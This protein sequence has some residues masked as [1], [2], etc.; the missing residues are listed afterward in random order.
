MRSIDI[1]RL[2]LNLL[3]VFDAIYREKNV[4]W[5]AR[6]LGKSQPNVSA[7]LSRLRDVFQDP[8]F[9]RNGVGVKATDRAEE[10]GPSIRVALEQLETSLKT[11]SFFEPK[12][13]SREF[14]ISVSDYLQAVLLPEL[15]AYLDK[16]A[17]DIG[18]RVA[19]LP[20]DDAALA[21]KEGRLD[22]LVSSYPPASIQVKQQRLFSDEHVF[23][24]RADHPEI[25]ETITP[26]QLAQLRVADLCMSPLTDKLTEKWRQQGVTADPVL[27]MSICMVAPFVA[28]QSDVVFLLP[29]REAEKFA[30]FFR[31]R[32]APLPFPGEKFETFQYWAERS[33]T[34]PAHRWL[35]KTVKRVAAGL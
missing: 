19:N 5:A 22:L 8:L 16:E 2:D 6:S 23:A 21:L 26:K 13:A 10:L 20:T 34:D 7:A 12:T 25:G 1:S 27:W 31:M 35:R 14:R 18:L 28:A 32:I 15:M 11:R 3:V 24:F 30:Q 29:K 17:P 4:S 9:V 33:D